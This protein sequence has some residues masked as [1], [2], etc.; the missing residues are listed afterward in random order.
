[1]AGSASRADAV[2]AALLVMGRE[3]AAEFAAR[4]PELG[5]LWLEPDQDVVR[6]W[7]WNLPAARAAA[8]VTVEWNA[9]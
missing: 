8:G 9:E 6:G 7:T 4:H 3:G 2:A 1:M 5:V